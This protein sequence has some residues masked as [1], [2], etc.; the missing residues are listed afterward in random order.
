M[1]IQIVLGGMISRENI[2]CIDG[3]NV[4]LEFAYEG[5]IPCK[6]IPASKRVHERNPIFPIQDVNGYHNR[7]KNWTSPFNGV[8]AK[9]RPNFLG[10]GRM[11]E[12]Q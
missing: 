2:L 3:G 1:S 6:V 12:K 4:L 11:F 7:R 5:N 9:Y 8:T 10:W